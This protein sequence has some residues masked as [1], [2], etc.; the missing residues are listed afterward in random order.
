VQHI[1]FNKIDLIIQRSVHLD[2]DAIIDFITN[3]CRVSREELEDME[4]PR[5][6]SLQRLVEV[7]D[8]NMGRI[9]FVW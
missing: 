6:F 9:R 5:K 8:F 2:P 7:A 4:N 1:D 3:L